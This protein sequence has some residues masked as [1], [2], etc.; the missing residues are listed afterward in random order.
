[1]AEFSPKR[2]RGS[3]VGALNA[4]W[5][6]GYA[7]SFVVGYLLLPLGNE[8]SWRWMLAS[9][10]VPGLLWLLSSY[11]MPESSRWLIS[12]GREKEANDVL[13]LIGDNVILPEGQESE[14]KT[15]FLDIF[16]H[17]YGKWVFFV[18][19]FWSLQVLPTFGIGTYIPMIMEGFGFTEGNIQ[20]LGAA[21][22]NAFYL[23]GLIPYLF[24]C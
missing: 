17:G 21:I 18:A 4:F 16:R 14:E 13:K 6:I 12:K 19:A 5:Y 3:L 15:A 24:P 20:Y 1:M 11:V 7:C 23:L 22:M 9:S 2:H 8:T 10:A